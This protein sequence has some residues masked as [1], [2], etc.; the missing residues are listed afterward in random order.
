MASGVGLLGADRI[1]DENC[2][3]VS[4]GGRINSYGYFII[5][6]SVG[7]N[8]LAF[9]VESGRVYW[10]DRSFFC[11]EIEVAI[12][13]PSGTYA[14]QAYSPKA[15]ENAMVGVSDSL[16]SFLYLLLADELTAKMDELDS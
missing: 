16:E 6:T 13:H 14:Y 9:H 3:A 5:A 4:P 1:F 7:G 10:V 2:P 11:D 8:A 15:V 12:R